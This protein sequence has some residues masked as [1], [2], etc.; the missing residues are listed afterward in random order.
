MSAD[1]DAG[2]T[3]AGASAGR[4]RHRVAV[5]GGGVAGL[6]AAYRLARAGLRPAVYEA[7][8]QT[9][10]KISASP[11]A[12]VPVDAG[13]ES[14]L[15]RRPEALELVREL[16][17][18]DRIAR[19]APGPARIYSRGRLRPF[20]AGHVMGVPG[21]P[22][23]LARSGVLSPAGALRAAADL[24]LPRT[25]ARGDVAVADYVGARM[26]A[27]VVDRLVEPML[28]GVYAGRTER[29]SLDA[30]LPQVA[31]AARARRSLM[32]GVHALVRAQR[33]P[34]AERGGAPG[35][36][37]ATLTGGL[38]GL[39]AALAGAVAEHGGTV[40]TA[41]PVTALE[42]HGGG[43]RVHTADG[44]ADV[45][46]VVLAAPAPAAA[47]LLRAA[48]PDAAGLLGG[49]G[50]AGMAIAAFA[51]RSGD[52]PGRP[53]GSGF[54]VSPREGLTVKAATFSSTKWPW[55][56]DALAAAHPGEDLTVVRCSIGRAGEEAAL[57]AG[58]AELAE[59]ARADLGAVLG[60]TPG[61]PLD[62]R[63]TRWAE[64][65]PQYDV[66]HEARIGGVRSALAGLPALELCGAAYDGVG[67]PACIA[68][69]TRAAERI[70]AAV[71]P[72]GQP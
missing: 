3:A 59:T 30:A 64:G 57:R 32:R 63:V 7:A 61:T 19:P 51:F 38:A 5:V 55:L 58:D 42:P 53:D 2:G 8:P 45:D 71:H 33:A 39:P 24:V 44:R 14:V 9:G 6:T 1:A 70:A 62:T 11:V 50:Y 15:T 68:G 66:G 35:P 48:A 25:P 21:D 41:T 49:I 18:S 34:A 23:A 16:G 29:L 65:L 47:A 54:L 40:H 26:G 17:L 13:A 31:P 27:E 4:S 67:I 36:P 43:W 28:G 56:A 22:V 37:F 12:G 72:P 52:L 20:P 46:A 69:A 60:R 10:G